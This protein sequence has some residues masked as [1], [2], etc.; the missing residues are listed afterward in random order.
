[1]AT[2]CK[3]RFPCVKAK[4][5]TTEETRSVNQF[6]KIDLC[7]AAN[8]FVTQDATLTEDQVRIAASENVIEHI[9]TKVEGNT[10]KITSDRCING[11]GN[12]TIYIK[13]N[14]LT[15]VS[16]SGSGDVIAREPVES[17]SMDLDISGSGSIEM[18]LTAT[19]I[20]A[21]ISGSG[22]MDLTG[23]ASELTISISGSGD[24][25][26]V[27][28]ETNRTNVS[29]VG[30]GSADVNVTERLDVSISGSGNVSYIG[31]PDLHVSLSGSGDIINNN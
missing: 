29:I 16:I 28:L 14:D 25:E 17:T 8:V 31:Q 12:I 21:G 13:S 2:S 6:S 15:G 4:T 27:T 24:I 22:N 23:F 30:S 7:I 20:D 26:A 10:L 18:E 9:E 11:N 1:S 19:S 3:K 5:T